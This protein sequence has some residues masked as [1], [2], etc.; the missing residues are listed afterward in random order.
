MGYRGGKLPS[1]FC[2]LSGENISELAKSGSDENTALAS[3][4]LRPDQIERAKKNKRWQKAWNKASAEWA[5]SK[6]REISE[7]KDVRILSLLAPKTMP[8][9]DLGERV[10]FTIDAPEWF[11]KS[12]EKKSART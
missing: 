12:L 10:V 5:V 8:E 1:V 4:G 3:L 6:N 11:I 9:T 2:Q 7:S